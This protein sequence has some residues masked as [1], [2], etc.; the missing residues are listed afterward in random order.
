MTS[1]LTPS[2]ALASDPLD[3]QM[4]KFLDLS[5]DILSLVRHENA[6]LLETGEL[7]FEAY[8]MRKATLMTDFEK[9]A[10]KLLGTLSGRNNRMNAQVMLVEEIRR[11]RDALKVNS[12][13]QLD[14][15]RAR[16]QEKFAAS[17][18][19]APFAGV[20]EEGTLCH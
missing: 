7:S 9:E 19:N 15:I 3:T 10:R 4:T 16:M 14:S 5:Q 11:V 1:A 18:D 12:G 6:I 17:E 20:Q 8:V 13:F 2:K